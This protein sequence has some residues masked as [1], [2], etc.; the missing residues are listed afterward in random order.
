MYIN[1]YYTKADSYNLEIYYNTFSMILYA[2]SIIQSIFGLKIVRL[3]D[4]KS[5]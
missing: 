5:E 3:P 2:L 4:E 1:V